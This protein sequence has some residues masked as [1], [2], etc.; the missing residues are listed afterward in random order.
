[1]KIRIVPLIISLALIGQVSC[2]E[3]KPSEKAATIRN[4]D[5]T[6]CGGCGGWFVQVDSASYRADIPAPY[7]R[8][9]T[10]VWIRFRKDESDGNKIHGQ[11]I[12]ITS[13]RDRK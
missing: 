12:I 2:S 10:P 11:W 3:V 7:N 5:Y 9:N 6:M 1:M 4:V 13:I 8:E